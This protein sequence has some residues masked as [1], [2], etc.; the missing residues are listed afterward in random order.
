MWLYFINITDIWLL[1]GK[2]HALVLAIHFI[3]LQD[4]FSASNFPIHL[5]HGIVYHTDLYNHHAALACTSHL[6]NH[7]IVTIDWSRIPDVA[8]QLITALCRNPGQITLDIDWKCVRKLSVVLEGH[9]GSWT[10]CEVYIEK[11]DSFGCIFTLA[12]IL[13]LY[14][15]QV[16]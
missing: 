14:N 13:C 5:N 7:W 3:T 9:E 2:N 6:Y 8:W 10:T 16:L 4:L 11:I 15:D 1:C 12:T